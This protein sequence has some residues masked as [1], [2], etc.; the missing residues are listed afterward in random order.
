MLA[1][2]YIAFL[3]INWVIVCGN[4]G[5]AAAQVSQYPNPLLFPTKPDE[6]KLQENQEIT[7]EQAIKLAT[8][9][10]N[11]RQVSLLQVELSQA[12][13]REAQASLFPTFD[14]NA[15]LTRRRDVTSTL[16]AQQSNFSQDFQNIEFDTTLFR[17][18][19]GLRY[20]IFSS[21][22]TAAR[23]K[24][25][26]EQLRFDE[27]GVISAGVRLNVT[28]DYYNL[29]QADE[30]VRIA[31]S[32]VQNA[33]AS[34]KD[35]VELERAG[36]GTR[37]DLL[38][39]QVN[40]AN[41]QQQLTS[42]ISQQQI[43]RRQLATRL[44][45]SQLVN[46]SAADPVQIAGLWDKTLEETI[47]LAYQNRSELK[48]QLARRNIR[49]QEKKEALSALG[50]KVNAT[51]DYNL[52]DRFKDNNSIS[53]G[54]SAALQTTLTVFDGGT[55]TAQADQ[56]RANMK[57]AEVEFAQQRDNIRFEVEQAFS[58]RISTLNN[59]QTANTA[60]EQAK[61]ALR[62]AR[63]RFQAGVGTQTDVINAQNDLTRAEGNRV[64]AILD[65]NRALARL[66]RA[67]S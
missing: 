26:E 62:L 55:A 6:V 33:Q 56:A 12:S 19:A 35:A 41:A 5:L 13:V 60:L 14:V 9:N 38:R 1:H 40:L 39:S 23:I 20:S 65:Y 50:P 52:L 61:E 21:G 34:L 42:S 18:Q 36:V 24:K 58:T 2:R 29:Q 15:S 64:T 43:A 32:A 63:L 46:V 22:T 59:V 49:E 27:L 11:E 54:Y 57:I 51:L 67:V 45:L 44:N 53:D 25:A 10:N 16:N 17:S 30:Q 37:F 66:K 28:L 7:L 48:Q 47:I 31:Q 4:I 8:L 3:S